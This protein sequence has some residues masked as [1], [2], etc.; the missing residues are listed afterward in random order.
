MKTDKLNSILNRSILVAILTKDGKEARLYAH[1]ESRGY[2]TGYTPKEFMYFVPYSAN[3]VPQSF[4][5]ITRDSRR[6]D[7]IARVV[8]RGSEVSIIDNGRFN[9]WSA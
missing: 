3:G 8:A 2:Q 5:G 9:K 4:T 6:K 7:F 1:T